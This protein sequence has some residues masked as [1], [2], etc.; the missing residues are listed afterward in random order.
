MVKQLSRTTNGSAQTNGTS[1]IPSRTSKPPAKVSPNDEVKSVGK[2]TFRA[3]PKNGVS[4]TGQQSQSVS[5]EKD[6]E[7]SRIK[8]QNGQTKVTPDNKA[9]K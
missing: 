1:T 2:Q 6:K 8:P 5:P 7:S 9:N 3:A 4:G